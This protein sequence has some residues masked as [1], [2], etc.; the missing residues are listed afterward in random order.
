MNNYAVQ[1]DDN[2]LQEWRKFSARL[3]CVPDPMT[4]RTAELFLNGR[5][6][7]TAGGLDAG[8]VWGVLDS[9]LHGLIAFFNMLMT[10]SAIPL[11]AYFETFRQEE[12]QWQT[13]QRSIVE[14]LDTAERGL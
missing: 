11:I 6:G 12:S 9:N 13:G 10:R 7:C 4:I 2:S 14:F 5:S 3:D 1:I 8:A